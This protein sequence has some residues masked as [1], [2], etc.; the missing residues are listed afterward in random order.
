VTQNEFNI[1]LNVASAICAALAVFNL[2]LLKKRGNKAFVL[3]VAFLVLGATLLLYIR[4]GMSNL[5]IG[6]GSIVILLLGVDFF[7]R[8][9]TEQTRRKR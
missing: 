3:A 9:P 4:Q 8:A 5:V 6:G 2:A 1:F 7:L